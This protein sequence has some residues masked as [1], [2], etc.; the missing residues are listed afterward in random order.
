[1]TT[2]LAYTP[3][4]AGH[5]FP[6]VPGLRELQARDHRVRV[7]TSAALLDTISSARARRRTDRPA[8]PGHPHRREVGDVRRRAALQRDVRPP[9]ARPA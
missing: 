3:A 7:R 2:F 6:L 8:D 5:V 9:R 1:M 4:A